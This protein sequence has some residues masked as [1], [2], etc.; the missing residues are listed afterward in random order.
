MTSKIEDFITGIPGDVTGLVNAVKEEVNN[1]A[2]FLQF[3][4]GVV[5]GIAGNVTATFENSTQAG[6]ELVYHFPP[7][8]RTL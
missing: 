1:T 3:V 7:H 8:I 6:W 2:A 4:G 5:A